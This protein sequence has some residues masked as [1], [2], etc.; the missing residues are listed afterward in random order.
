MALGG[1]SQGNA[2]GDLPDVAQAASGGVGPDNRVDQGRAA[3]AGTPAG[4][5]IEHE[6]SW[7][8]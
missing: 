2:A 8:L 3:S 7:A 1:G 6:A 5:G 4:Q